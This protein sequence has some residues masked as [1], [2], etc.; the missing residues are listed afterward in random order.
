MRVVELLYAAGEKDSAYALAT[1]AANNLQD[2]SQIA[3]LAS[4][5]ARQQDAHL[6]LTIGKLTAA[7]WHPRRSPRLPHIRHPAL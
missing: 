7:A 3:A 6:A 4:V 2:D 1:D 5:I